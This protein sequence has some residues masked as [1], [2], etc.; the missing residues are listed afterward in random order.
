MNLVFKYGCHKT[1]LHR[2]QEDHMDV[3]LLAHQFHLNHIKHIQK[4]CAFLVWHRSWNLKRKEEGRISR[5]LSVVRCRRSDSDH[6]PS[7]WLWILQI[8]ILPWETSSHNLLCT[9]LMK[10]QFSCS[11]THRRR[12]AFRGGSSHSCLDISAANLT[13]ALCQEVSCC[14]TME[15]AIKGSLGLPCRTSSNPLL[16]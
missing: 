8:S 10:Y 12:S 5:W 6:F 9:E 1:S 11:L 13:T 15:T 4:R 3:I 2:L 14:P 16:F 7:Q